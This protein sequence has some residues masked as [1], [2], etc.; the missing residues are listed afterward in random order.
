MGRL[1]TYKELVNQ[2]PSKAKIQELKGETA[3]DEDL[4]D[5]QLQAGS[6]DLFKVDW[7]R[8]ILDEAHAIK[9]ESSIS[10]PP[11]CTPPSSFII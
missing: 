8:V 4:F 2:F 6:G 3:G 11:T 9:N 7:Y 10:E 1:I 5:K